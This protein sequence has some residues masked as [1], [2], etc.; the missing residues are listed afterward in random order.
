[1][2]VPSWLDLKVSLGNILT[3]LAG[4]V[5]LAVGWTELRADNRRQDQELQSLRAAD[6][7]M[8]VSLEKAASSLKS[9]LSEVKFRS[10]QI[11][12]KLVEKQQHTT[13]RVV[14][15][16]TKIDEVLKAVAPPNHM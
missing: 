15:V 5:G 11:L 16:E 6:G 7:D 9:D 10:D 2:S 8:R 1:M 14:R 4:I 13:E 3:I 12:E